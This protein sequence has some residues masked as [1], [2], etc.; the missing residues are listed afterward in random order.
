MQFPNKQQYTHNM[1]DKIA[2]LCIILQTAITYSYFLAMLL[3]N[4]KIM[5]LHRC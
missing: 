5:Y 4:L 3:N 1:K 2:I